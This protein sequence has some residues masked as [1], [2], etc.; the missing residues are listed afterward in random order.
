MRVNYVVF[1]KGLSFTYMYTYIHIYT[2]Q[3]MNVY[4]YLLPKNPQEFLTLFDR[5]TRS[6]L[7]VSLSLSLS[8]RV[9]IARSIAIAS[10]T[11]LYLRSSS[12]FHRSHCMLSFFPSPLYCLAAYSRFSWWVMFFT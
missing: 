10:G 9:P 4:I 1:C 6:T 3:P 5:R 7:W 11:L 12:H 2:Y 8:R